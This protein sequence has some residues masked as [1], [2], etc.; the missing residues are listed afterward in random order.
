MES[1]VDD[2]IIKKKDINS[3]GK[4]TDIK[5]KKGKEIK[6]RKD[7]KGKDNKGKDS[8]GKDSKGKDSKGKDSKGK[9]SKGKDSKGKQQ[10]KLKKKNSKKKTYVKSELLTSR[11]TGK[12]SLKKRKIQRG[13]VEAVE[14]D[15]K[16]NGKK[17]LAEKIEK[18]QK[19]YEE[20][21][22]EFITNMKS[23]NMYAT[24]KVVKHIIRILEL[25]HANKINSTTITDQKS[26]DE[27]RME[28]VN[29]RNVYNARLYGRLPY[30]FLIV[31]NAGKKKESKSL[32]P[33]KKIDSKIRKDW[34]RKYD[35]SVM[36]FKD[37]GK[38][39]KEHKYA[40]F[41]IECYIRKMRESELKY[42]KLF[43]TLNNLIKRFRALF[44]TEYMT[45]IEALTKSSELDS[46]LKDSQ[47]AQLEK[48]R[49]H[50]TEILELHK[51]LSKID[52]DARMVR[53]NIRREI[54]SY[55]P[56]YGFERFEKITGEALLA[57][58]DKMKEQ[59]VRKYNQTS[60][61]V[62]N[63]IQKLM[64][65]LS[66]QYIDII[67]GKT[68]L[69]KLRR[70][71]AD[72]KNST[73][74]ISSDIVT[75]IMKVDSDINGKILYIKS[76]S[77]MNIQHKDKLT[78]IE[79][80]KGKIYKRLIGLIDISSES[81]DRLIKR[82]AG[83]VSLA[84]YKD[85]IDEKYMPFKPHS[86]VEKLI[87]QYMDHNSVKLDNR[88]INKNAYRYTKRELGI[89]IGASTVNDN[90][91]GD[92][93]NDNNSDLDNAND[94][95]KQKNYYP[96]LDVNY[97]A[98]LNDNDIFLPNDI[99]WGTV[100]YLYTQKIYLL[101]YMNH[102]TRIGENLD[103]LKEIIGKDYKIGGKKGWIWKKD[104]TY[105]DLNKKDKFNW[106]LV[107]SKIDNMAYCTV[108]E[109]LLYIYYFNIEIF[110]TFTQVIE[111]LYE[112]DTYYD[113]ANKVGET[114][115][116]GDMTFKKINEI[117]S[118]PALNIKS[119]K[120]GDVGDVSNGIIPSR[121]AD[122]LND[123]PLTK[124][125]ELVDLF[126]IRTILVPKDNTNRQIEEWFKKID[127]AMLNLNNNY[128]TVVSTLTS[129]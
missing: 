40:E 80:L 57:L 88:F 77:D 12:K 115:V 33:F 46:K 81:S 127:V 111:I 119:A 49:R 55:F 7:S 32:V 42:N 25:I 48:M 51:K 128:Q 97:Y 84:N 15:L 21:S 91:L 120:V 61:N 14:K 44:S 16:F 62:R 18:Y 68:E 105:E 30:M 8:K 73:G 65:Q 90:D 108:I 63:N 101:D 24:S 122:D 53:R 13:G 99:I 37:C 112:Y 83:V 117:T 28:I 107:D 17:F 126:S 124:I 82:D 70:K 47:R 87:N 125:F 6:K 58:D 129:S 72:H 67:N 76:T 123:L 4:R 104:R 50:K 86:L 66:E 96:L 110:I 60:E 103:N 41:R 102:F 98:M 22:S 109:L 89:Q 26:F 74:E 118:N 71:L 11:C 29:S 10:H 35:R 59:Y 34:I 54:K 69:I 106:Q 27:N 2:N 45:Q 1:D 121:L 94:L 79:T 19:L 85:K 78:Q 52:K 114:I 116:S 100:D 9:D 3:K 39:G 93:Y 31:K 5:R 64:I 23:L 113:I 43:Y 95:D 36:E 38:D 20:A 56:Y 92:I 75:E